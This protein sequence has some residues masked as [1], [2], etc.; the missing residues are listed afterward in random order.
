MYFALKMDW[1]DLSN[2]HGKD[3]LEGGKEIWI[4]GGN[5]GDL[6]I[7]TVCLSFYL[8]RLEKYTNMAVNSWS[9]GL[10]FII[11]SFCV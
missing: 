6:D 2:T 11:F 5:K 8:K 7:S 9:Q 1:K 3:S 4:Q 10:M